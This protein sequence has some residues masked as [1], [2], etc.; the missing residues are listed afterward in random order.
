MAGLRDFG[1]DDL[2]VEANARREWL[3]KELGVDLGGLGKG[4]VDKG[5]K[6]KNIENIVGTVQVPVG[7][8]GPVGFEYLGEKQEVYLPLATTE[9]ALVA[10]VG[11]GCKLVRE[12]KEAKVW[13]EEVGMSRA[14][15]FVTKGVEEGLQ[16]KK[17]VEDNQKTIQKIAE[18]SDKH[19]HY[20]G[21]GCWVVGKQVYVRMSF[22]CDEAMGMNMVTIVSEKVCGVIEEELK[23]KCVALSGNMC[24][25]KKPAGVNRLSGRGKRVWAEIEVL[26]EAVEQVLH[27]KVEQ[28]LEVFTRK[29]MV[30]SVVAESSGFNAHAAN[31]VAAMF[32]ATGQDLAHVVHGSEAMVTM[33]KTEKGLYVSVKLEGL[34]VGTVGGGTGG[35]SQQ[36]S[37]A[38]M[39]LGANKG[40]SRKL[41]AM[42]G[43]GVLAGEL[44]LHGALASGDLAK[45][46]ANLGR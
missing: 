8:V 45:A 33:E 20:L 28:V 14:P 18:Q 6:G 30:G 16:V 29:T 27:A 43:V 31:I 4:E 41:A 23:V 10:S 24:S 17:W 13:V 21:S 25:D 32:L 1:D 3:E 5:W 37:L 7:V 9:G 11:R 39:G 2:K 22:D 46:H 44:S 38:M 12:S 36:A 40:D 35:A 19:V 34:A 26:E 15:V 42:V